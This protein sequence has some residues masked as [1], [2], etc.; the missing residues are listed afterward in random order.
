MNRRKKKTS[1]YVH[2]KYFTLFELGSFL[3]TLKS[4]SRFEILKF[5]AYSSR[6]YVG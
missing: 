1:E 5:M 6:P 2:A 3:I 4:I